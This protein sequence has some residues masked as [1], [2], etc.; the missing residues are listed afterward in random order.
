M[1][2]LL[3]C[4]QGHSWRPEAQASCP[5][6]GSLPNQP[7]AKLYD[8]ATAPTLPPQNLEG[9]PPAAPQP[10][11]NPN[12]VLWPTVKG[13]EIQGVLG[14][15]GMGIVYKARQIGLDRLVALK[16]VLGGI[17]ATP[18][19]LERFRREAEAV[20]KLQHPNIVQIY[21][22]GDCDGR[23]YLSLEFIGGGSLAQ[24]LN[25]L[26][27]P[28]AKAAGLVATLARAIHLAHERGIVHRDLKPANVLLTE[29]GTPKITDFGL[30]KRLDRDSGRT[31]SGAI[32]GTP[33]Y[34]A[35]EQ[36]SGRSKDV[37]PATDVYAL[38]AILY[39]LLT[40]QAPFR[41]D[42]PIDTV[43]LVLEREP[44]PPRALNPSASRELEAICLKCLEKN[45]ADR[46]L[47]A[48]ALAEDL[49]RY[50]EG[51]AISAGN[52]N[53]MNRLART[54]DRSQYDVDFRDWSS[55]LLLF[56]PIM[57]LAHSALFVL[58][59]H[60][61][62][63][64]LGW[65]RTVHLTEYGLLGVVYWI[66]GSGRLRA[67]S[68]SERLLR[69]IWLG[70]IAAS[71]IL[72]TINREMQL[73]DT[74]LSELALYPSKAVLAG[75]AFFAMG[76]SYWGRCYAFGIAFFL[77]AVTMPLKLHWAPLLFGATWFVVLLRLG[78]RLRWLNQ[79][80]IV[81]V[82]REAETVAS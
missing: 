65:T 48:A 61:P 40:G 44:P 4:A 32:M 62:P 24:K 9:Q 11:L 57:L 47:S 14:R 23:P 56:A 34:M 69:S 26:P 21:E 74:T 46:Y 64:P 42:T 16:M 39:E 7:S 8:N 15:G 38:G 25:G 20:A 28:A 29:D 63:F 3:T 6:C 81:D 30:A 54:L 72:N 73:G 22:V 35:P 18:D 36:A 33:A 58:G 55:M 77:L 41:A 27:M 66:Y 75:L 49:E 51:I 76:G 71:V 82:Q 43:L 12:L 2:E 70:Y 17:H 68:S 45:K 78:L 50:L 13:Y 79:R 80:A 52:F 59:L 37:G 31:R 10:E 60:E 53:V 1:L 67:A 5:V 19:E